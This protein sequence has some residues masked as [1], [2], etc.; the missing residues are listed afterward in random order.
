[1][2]FCIDLKNSFSEKIFSKKQLNFIFIFLCLLVFSCAEKPPEEILKPDVKDGN[3]NIVVSIAK[4]DGAKYLNIFRA[5]YNDSIESSE[6]DFEKRLSNIY[7][8]AQVTPKNDVLTSYVFIDNYFVKGQNYC[9]RMRYWDGISYKVTSWSDPI[10]SNSTDIKFLTNDNLR[11]SI[12]D[13]AYFLFDS[14]LK[15]LQIK[16]DGSE[17][18]ITDISNFDS[19]IDGKGFRPALAFS[20]GEGND[21]VVKIF[22]SQIKI[23][24]TESAKPI[25]LRSLLT[26]DFFDKDIKLKYIVSQKNNEN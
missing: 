4:M 21:E 24:L 9:Y 6:P 14:E 17:K 1:M 11:Y 7:N 10:S 8:I 22:T 18:E 16:F 25:D 3:G 26:D 20:Y 12:P 19:Y 13:G 15:Q 5:E 23:E 2:K